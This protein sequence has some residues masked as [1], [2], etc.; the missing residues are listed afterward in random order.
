MPP[1]AILAQAAAPIPTSDAENSS[2]LSYLYKDR[3]TSRYVVR[4]LCRMED[5]TFTKKSS[6]KE[7]YFHFHGR[8]FIDADILEVILDPVTQEVVKDPVAA[9]R[10]FSQ[11]EPAPRKNRVR[12]R[13]RVCDVTPVAVHPPIPNAIMSVQEKNHTRP[14][15]SRSRVGQKHLKDIESEQ[16]RRKQQEE[17]EEDFDFDLLTHGDWINPHFAP[18]GPLSS[19][20][21]MQAVSP[22]SVIDLPAELQKMIYTELLTIPSSADFVPQSQAPGDFQTAILDVCQGMRAIG[23]DILARE[24]ICKYS[25]AFFVVFMGSSPATCPRSAHPQL[26]LIGFDSHRDMCDIRMV[27]HARNRSVTS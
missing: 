20:R 19:N 14:L 5:T 23:S 9:E 1:P 15:A 7:H 3:A 25:T 10:A 21:Y 6:A 16:E 2:R 18:A 13:N 17:E 12:N 27:W 11:L 4:Y 8:P 24:N 22:R 26:M